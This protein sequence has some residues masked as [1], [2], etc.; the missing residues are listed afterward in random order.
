MAKRFLNNI[1]INDSYSLP[2][3]DGDSGQIITTDGSGSLSFVNASSV[4]VTGSGV[5]TFLPV[6]NTTTGLASSNIYQNISG[7][8]IVDTGVSLTGELIAT[9]H[10]TATTPQ[11]VN[12]VYGTSATP[13]VAS[14]TTEG[15]LYIQYTP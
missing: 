3:T 14:T 8:V 10:G 4:A 2:A 1:T 5:A 11:V 6:W 12:V 9:D 7:D 13:P 15:T